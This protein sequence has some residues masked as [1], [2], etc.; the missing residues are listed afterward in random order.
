MQRMLSLAWKTLSQG[1]SMTDSVGL[2]WPFPLDAVAI[3]VAG[4][5]Y[6]LFQLLNAVSASFDHVLLST[7]CFHL[8][9]TYYLQSVLTLMF[10]KGK[11][12]LIKIQS[13]D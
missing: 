7:G 9:A 1:P 13:M 3:S 2:P 11:K 8:S 10:A 6:T 5:P 4:S 12:V